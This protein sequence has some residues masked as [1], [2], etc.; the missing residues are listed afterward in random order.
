MSTVTSNISA[1][2]KGLDEINSE[3]NQ[4]SNIPEDKFKPVM[5]ISSF[6]LFSNHF[7]SFDFWK[8]FVTN[9]TAEYKEIEQKAAVVDKMFKEAASFFG[10]PNAKT[11]EFFKIISSFV[12]SFAVKTTLLISI[13]YTRPTMI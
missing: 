6:S 9:A 11:E 4:P 1:I 5:S 12:D 10:E 2:K 13:L 8:A 7:L 3:L